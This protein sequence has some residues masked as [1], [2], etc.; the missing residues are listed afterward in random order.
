MDDAISIAR[1]LVE[2]TIKGTFRQRQSETLPAL[3]PYG[4][5]AKSMVPM[6]RSDGG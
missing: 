1:N 5:L 4:A 2:Y 3:D 6:E